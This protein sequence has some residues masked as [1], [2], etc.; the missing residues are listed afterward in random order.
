[1]MSSSS[2]DTSLRACPVLDNSWFGN[3]MVP[4]A[5]LLIWR[6]TPKGQRIVKGLVYTTCGTSCACGNID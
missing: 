4:D 2:P 3:A 5:K 1:M 6:A